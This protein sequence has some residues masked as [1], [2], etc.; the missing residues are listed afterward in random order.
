MVGTQIAA[1]RRGAGLTQ[2][3]LAKIIHVSPS[4]IGMY[5]QGRR[6]PAAPILVALS[7][8]L[9]VSLDYLVTGIPYTPKDAA[10]SCPAVNS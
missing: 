10:Q 1:L 8:V 2:A 3:E 5:E 6:L 4:T 7:R 9:G